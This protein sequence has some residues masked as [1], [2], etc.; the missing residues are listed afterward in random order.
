MDERILSATYNSDTSIPW[1][2]WNRTCGFSL[3]GF[4]SSPMSHR[5]VMYA[6]MQYSFVF[7]AAAGAADGAPQD[8]QNLAPSSY[9]VPHFGQLAIDIPP[10]KILLSLRLLYNIDVAKV[11]R[12]FTIY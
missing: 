6:N 1:F 7:D 4:T 5:G 9:C 11:K 3:S 2:T 10:K 12:E 8:G